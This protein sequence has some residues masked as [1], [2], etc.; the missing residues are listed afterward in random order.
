MALAVACSCGGAQSPVEAPQF[1]E[2]S[3]AFATPPVPVPRRPD[4]VVLEPPAALPVPVARAEARGIV[5]LRQPLASDAVADLVQSFVDAWQRESL[6][7]LTAM[8]AS[9]AGPID[10]RIRGRGALIEAWR[11]RMH[12]HEYG[13]LA[14]VE[15]VRPERI[16]RWDRDELGAP[17]AP[18]RPADIR[19]GEI[20]VRA[21]LEATRVAGEKLFGDV[22]VMVLRPEGGKL[23]IAAYGEVDA[24]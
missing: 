4:A 15:L 1:P 6:D 7:A 22:L 8:L 10:G 17:D 23:K 24:P 11:Q 14:N 18:A 12:A 19:P 3:H 13:R 5:S 16:A 21:P 2:S 9:D 20:Y